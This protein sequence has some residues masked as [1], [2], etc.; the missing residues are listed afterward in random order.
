LAQTGLVA[1]KYFDYLKDIQNMGIYFM[2]PNSAE[3]F[4]VTG[5]VACAI[6]CKIIEEIYSCEGATLIL[7]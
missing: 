7:L 6:S 2:K 3:S 1:N 5:H 4:G